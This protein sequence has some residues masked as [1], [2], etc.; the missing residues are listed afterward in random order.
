MCVVVELR[1]IWGS[2]LFE[3]WAAKAAIQLEVLRIVLKVVW[4]FVCVCVCVRK[5][6]ESKCEACSFRQKVLSR[7]TPG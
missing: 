7:K 4:D 3:S 1:R 6:N 5:H 2:E